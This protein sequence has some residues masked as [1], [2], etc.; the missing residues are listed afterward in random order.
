MP[1]P[2]PRKLAMRVGDDTDSGGY[3]EVGICFMVPREM[4]LLSWSRRGLWNTYPDWHIG[5]LQG[6]ALKHNPYGVC[7]TG[8]APEWDW[9][10]DEKDT[11]LFGKYDTGRRGTRDFCSMKRMSSGRP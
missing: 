5:R 10:L 8:V 9:Q 11:V 2:S 1:Y 6:S 7:R 3:E 4:D